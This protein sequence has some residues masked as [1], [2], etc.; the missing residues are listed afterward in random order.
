MYFLIKFKG[1]IILF[2]STS[3]LLQGEKWCVILIIAA[4]SYPLWSLATF[5]IFADHSCGTVALMILGQSYGPQISE[6]WPRT[7]RATVP[8]LY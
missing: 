2:I 5:L 4:E 6:N 3:G 7:I 1:V 8:Q